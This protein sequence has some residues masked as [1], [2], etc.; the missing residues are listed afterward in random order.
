[1]P[2]DLCTLVHPASEP[3][4]QSRNVGALLTRSSRLHGIKRTDPALRTS[5]PNIWVS[6]HLQAL[7]TSSTP[8]YFQLEYNAQTKRAYSGPCPE[9]NNLQLPRTTWIIA[10]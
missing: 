6:A 4:D 3:P 10:G 2:V 9:V 8:A 5:V 1:M 7:L